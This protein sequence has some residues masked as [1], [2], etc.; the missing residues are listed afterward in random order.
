MKKLFLL[1]LSIAATCVASAQTVLES[2]TMPGGH[3][4]QIVQDQNGRIFRRLIKAN[5]NVAET[6]APVEKAPMGAIQKFE[7][8]FFESFEGWQKSYGLDWIPEGW[9]QKNL[10]ENIPTEAMLQN[11]RNLRWFVSESLP[12]YQ[13]VTDEG[14]N[15]AFIH[16]GYERKDLGMMGGP[17][18]EWLITPTISLKENETLHFMHQADFFSV[19]DCENFDWNNIKYPEP[20]VVVCNMSVLVTTDDGEN[21]TRVWDLDADVTSKLSDQECF[22]NA[23]L[24]YRQY[25]VDL[26]AFANNNVKIAFRYVCGA[27]DWT[28]NSMT[29][30]AVTI[31]HP[32][33]SGIN[34][35]AADS[36]TFEYY[37][38]NGAK[39]PGK[40]S[41]KGLY[42]RKGGNKTEKVMF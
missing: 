21:W 36:N 19:Y 17:Q 38:V 24:T 40:P 37:D 13:D 15:E 9:T 11:N 39:L 16:Y 41:K 22:D 31:N 8:T 42:I 29:L 30:D 6:V 12:Y 5:E 14:V 26:S 2:R 27:G 32:I 23:T 1:S 20:R 35:V 18:D 34:E 33:A 7:Q 28:G 4:S 3:E 10:P 25:H